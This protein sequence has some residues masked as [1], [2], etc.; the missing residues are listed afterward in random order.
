MMMTTTA[1][2]RVT[3]MNMVTETVMVR[4]GGIAVMGMAR[5]TATEMAM[6]M[7]MVM[8][9]VAT[10]AVGLMMGGGIG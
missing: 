8:G 2:A 1:M 3:G 4:R 6:A 9:T 7:G 5:V 10:T